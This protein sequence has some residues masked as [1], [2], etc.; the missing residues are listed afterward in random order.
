[1]IITYKK[2]SKSICI[3]LDGLVVDDNMRCGNDVYAAGDCCVAAWSTATQWLQMLLWT[4]AWQM[5]AFAGKCM[6][7]H[8]RDQVLPLDFCFELFAHATTFFSF[9]V[10]L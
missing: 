4:Q 9:K 6:V 7:A 5:G 2:K 8:T 10:M 1:M 3:F